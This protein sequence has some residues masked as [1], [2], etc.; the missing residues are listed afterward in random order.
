[1]S[2]F[3]IARR[4]RFS[5]MV[6][7][8]WMIAVFFLNQN[9]V[10]S[11]EVTKPNLNK[12][13]SSLVTKETNTLSI[14]GN[15]RKTV[16]DNGLTV[17]TKEVHNAPVV[18]V[19][20]W[21]K[22]GSGQE[23]PGV[24]GIAHQLEHLMFKG[25]SDRPVQFGRLFTLLGSDSNAFTSYD[26]TAY[27][28]TAEKDKL[29][30]LLTLEA[31]RMKN[32]VIND[33]HLSTEKQVVISELQGYENSPEY[34]LNRAI[35]AAAFPD[36]PYSLPISGTKKDVT[37]FTVDQVKEYYQK[38]YHPDNAVLVIVGDFVTDT[39]LKTVQEIFGNI[40]GGG[41]V[42]HAPD[43]LGSAKIP[44]S[45][46]KLKQPGGSKI[47]QVIYPLP[48]INHPDIPTLEILDYI[49]T[50]GKNSY[51][52]Q[53]LVESG[54]ASDIFGNIATLRS[55]GWYE[56][57]VTVGNNQ[58][59]G[60]IHSV[61]HRVIAKLGEDSITPEQVQIAKNQL[62]ATVILNNRDITSQAMQLANDETV[63]GDYKYID[64]HLQDINKVQTADVV[65]VI[66]KY[67]EPQK[68]IVG[69][70]QPIQKIKQVNKESNDK[71]QLAITGH[72]FV[73]D[74]NLGSSDINNIRKYLPAIEFVN[75]SR[76]KTIPQ[77][78]KLAN[79]LT[80]L[81]L[82]DKTTPTV[83]LS[84]NIKAGTEFDGNDQGG[85]ASLVAKNLINGEKTQ[86]LEAKGANL[87]FN[88]YREGVKI[89]GSSLALDLPVLLGT[90]SEV[91]K[92]NQI[93]TKQLEITREQ[94]L[95]NLDVELDDPDKVANR[96]FVQSIYPKKHPLHTFPTKKSIKSIKPEDVINFKMKH[97]RPDTTVLA[98][99]GNFDVREVRSLIEVNLGSWQVKGKAPN[100]N[101]PAVKMPRTVIKFNP[102]IPGKEQAITYMG[103]T[104]INRQDR[105]FYAAMVLNQIL[106]GD[107][108]SSR[109]GV[110]IRDR[111]GLT[112]G[113]YSYF[114]TGK[115]VGTFLI[116]MQTSPEDTNKAIFSTRKLLKQINKT[117]VTNEEI[118]AAKNNLISNYNISLSQPEELS[119][120]IVM[121][122]VYGL[123]QIELRSF[124]HKIKQVDLSQVNQAARELLH[125]DKIVVVTAGP[126][127]IANSY[128]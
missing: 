97:Y 42:S 27:Y 24:N 12:Y 124:I 66:H 112:Y 76:E 32:T 85:L 104:G 90:L 95:T 43:I 51:L 39:T 5:L 77:K 86:A 73:S 37:N 114:V 28:H 65:N 106:G 98:L 128:Q 20:V 36:H 18:T 29:T 41:Y 62:F 127:I 92:N 107:T 70:F 93:S 8:V 100:I 26:Q 64:H 3:Y 96:I 91:I 102:V 126:Q 52:Y 7:S 38:Y 22:V 11:L 75:E 80:V 111:Q 123:N 44:A 46:I 33:E 83:T 4:H 6:F 117:G 118:E 84:G 15:V 78:L 53:Q 25:T 89:E 13:H 103:Y 74:V 63:A 17:I 71:S 69:Y 57:T 110:E 122:E 94:A 101:Y 19:Q 55:G 23:A 47:L 60:K 50:S 81:L 14:T 109:L 2:F 48:P 121:N 61:L 87:A 35:M 30:A 105:R 99:V 56:I 1:M 9:A 116:E 31:D 79:G 40:P 45:P 68:A 113:I 108:L 58:D 16:L 115:N 67:I 120:R 59:L 119:T 82:P 10:M 88:A 54:L 125:P 72:N 21:Y 49:L 34:R